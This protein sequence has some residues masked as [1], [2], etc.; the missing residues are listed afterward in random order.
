MKVEGQKLGTVKS[1]KYLGAIVSDEGS[2][3]RSPDSMTTLGQCLLLVVS[4]VGPTLYANV[5]PT[6]LC[7]SGERSPNVL[8]QRWPNVVVFSYTILPI[9]R[10]HIWLTIANIKKSLWVKFGH[11]ISSYNLKQKQIPPCW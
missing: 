6:S 1:F 5:G 7:S 3:N 2:Q 9:L 10:Q 11:R 8:V 4:S